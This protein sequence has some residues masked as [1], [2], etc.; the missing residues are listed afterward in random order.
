M[1]KVIND[2]IVLQLSKKTNYDNWSL[3]MKTLLESQDILVQITALKKTQVKDKLALYFLYNAMDKS[4]FE[5]IANVASS[6]ET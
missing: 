2:M 5:K 3:Q 1:T 6:K 4:S